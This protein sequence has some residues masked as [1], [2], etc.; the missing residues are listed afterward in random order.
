MEVITTHHRAPDPLS[1]SPLDAAGYQS[2]ISKAQ[3]IL[4]SDTLSPLDAVIHGVR[5]RLHTNSAHWHRFWSANWFTPGQWGS[6]T[7]AAPPEEAKFQVYA[8]RTDSSGAPWAGYSLAKSTAFL[9]G[10]VSYGPLRALVLDTVARW[11]AEEEGVHFVP[12]LCI[13]RGSEVSLLLDAPGVDRTVALPALMNRSDAHL[14]AF[15]GVFVR[16]GLVRM[17]DGVTLLPTQVTD[18]QG[19]TTRG[20]HI[21]PWLDDY[22]FSEPRADVGCLRLDGKLEYC[23]ARDLDLGR[24]PDAMSFSVEKAWYLPT[25]LVGGAPELLGAFWPRTQSEA[26]ALLEN[27]PAFTPEVSQRLEPWASRAAST[28]P[29]KSLVEELGEAKVIEALCRLRA[30]PEARAMVTPQLLWP[31]RAGWNPWQPLR[32]HGVALLADDELIPLKASAL[33]EHLADERVRRGGLYGEEANKILTT[34]L[35]QAVSVSS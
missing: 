34:E 33:K 7:G 28:P 4:A 6:L 16:Y 20:Y 15:G 30:A 18:E 17:V 2:A 11:L 10:D 23:F 3:R 19:I 26:T 14:V 31:S 22:G 1:A 8:T 21:F 12:G 35:A 27:V 25:Q 5:V 9:S 29:V 13:K 32:V 24:I